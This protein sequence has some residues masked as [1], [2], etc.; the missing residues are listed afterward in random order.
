M[1]KYLLSFVA[2]SLMLSCGENVSEQGTNTIAAQPNTSGIDGKLLFTINCTQCHL[3]GKA[4][5]GPPLAGAEK[6]WPDKQLLY[7]FVRNSA[8]VIKKNE[9]AAG[10]FDKWKEAPMLPFP[11]LTD[12]EIDAILEYCNSTAVSK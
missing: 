5:V 3:P 7:Q 8:D 11:Q 12:Q 9:Y 10:L 4:F 6:N 1:I 2:M